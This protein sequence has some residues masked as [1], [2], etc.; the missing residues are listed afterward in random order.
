MAAPFAA[1]ILAAGKGTRMRSARP[2]VLHELAGKPMIAHVLGAVAGLKPQHTAVVIGPNQNA[3]AAA[4]APADFV[5]QRQPRGTGHA[6]ASAKALLGRYPGD[7]LIVAGD[8]PLVTRDTFRP[9]FEARRRHPEAAVIVLGMRLADGGPYG[10]LILADDGSLA[11][12]VEAADCSEEERAVDFVSSGVMLARGPVLF[13]L[14][15]GLGAHNAQGE[16]YLTDVIGL[17]R[18]KGLSCR[19]AEGDPAELLGVNSRDELAY[20]EAVMQQRLRYA[21]MEAGVGFTAPETVFLC[22]DTK[23][24]RDTVVGPFVVFGPGVKVGEG[25]SIPAFC[26]IAG[27]TIGDRAIIGPFARLR[28]GALLSDEVHIGNFVEVK[29]SRLAAGVKANHLAYLGDSAVGEGANI[30][31]GTITC[32]YDG[33]E[34]FRTNIGKG[35]FVGTNASLVAPLTI[36]PGAMIAAGSV[37]TDDVPADAL[38]LGRARQRTKPGAAKAWRA[39]RKAAIAARDAKPQAKGRR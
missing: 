10:R 27:A 26:H 6:V 34:K 11:R 2:K 37:I 21:L 16:Q 12:I 15:A 35:V 7:V 28:P 25:V 17:A 4:V 9:L 8:A 31:A 13:D 24:G 14:V 23:I 30:G 36:G 20:A 33:I 32:N 19:T 29:N 38:A 3:V 5:I 22:A 39:R 18:G 1:L